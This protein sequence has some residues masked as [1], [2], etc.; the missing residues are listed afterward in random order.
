VIIL[1]CS[2]RGSAVGDLDQRRLG[3]ERGPVTPAQRCRDQTGAV[4]VRGRSGG[5]RRSGSLHFA[6]FL[7]GMGS[8]ARVSV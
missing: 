5:G 8:D 6:R 4:A 3:N 1:C 2:Q 7:L